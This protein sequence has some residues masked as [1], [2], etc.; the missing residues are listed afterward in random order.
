MTW[1]RRAGIPLVLALAVVAGGCRNGTAPDD[2][3]PRNEP[4]VRDAAVAHPI[5]AT[6]PVVTPVPAPGARP[7][8][9]QD[10]AVS[11][12]GRTLSVRFARFC[13]AAATADV[14]EEDGVVTVTVRAADAP[15]PEGTYESCVT[16][17]DEVLVV[18]LNKPLRGREVVDGSARAPRPLVRSGG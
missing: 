10:A 14:A 4:R 6:T 8:A 7:L 2:V 18:R 17:R 13:D 5:S 3:H 15:V 16:A 12:D 11:A 9:W 1:V